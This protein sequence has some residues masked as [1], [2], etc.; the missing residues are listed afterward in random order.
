MKFWIWMSMLNVK[1][2]IKYNLIKKYKEP[3]YVY[4]LTKEE[5][6]EDGIELQDVNEILENKYKNNLEN[7]IQ[8]MKK[9]KI[10]IITIN[11]NNYPKM[12][13]NIYDPP[14]VL[15]IKGNK[16]IFST[17]AI[18]MIGCRNCSIYGK[19]TAQKL[20][21]DLAK[22]NFVVVSGLAKGID[23]YSHVGCLAGKGKTIAVLGNGLDT[24]YPSENKE[25]ADKIVENS[26]YKNML[27][28]LVSP[29]TYQKRL[30]K[31]IEINKNKKKLKLKK[32][33]K[34]CNTEKDFFKNKINKVKIKNYFIKDFY[35]ENA[36]DIISD[37]NKKLEKILIER[38]K[39]NA[40][41]K[42]D[43]M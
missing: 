7:Y 39:I 24:V 34:F 22:N 17:Y 41:T 15:Y 35:K 12:L 26:K 16:E 38:E 43:T 36:T 11:D 25:L 27:L 30:N 23:T 3:K 2:I 1:P 6:L 5:L 9:H 42:E 20:A 28:N 13:R 8:Y 29:F 32:N 31:W 19:N 18:G 33:N 10:K 37:Y 14:I 40:T 21:Y 4:K